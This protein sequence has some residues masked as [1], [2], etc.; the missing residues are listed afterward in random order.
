MTKGTAKIAAYGENRRGD[1][2]GVIDEREFL[3]A[4]DNH[5]LNSRTILIFTEIFV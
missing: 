3:Q 1:V 4:A 2:A 5:K